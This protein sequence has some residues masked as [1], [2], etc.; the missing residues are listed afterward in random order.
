[1]QLAVGPTA[2]T[3]VGLQWSVNRQLK[4]RLAVGACPTGHVVG[5]RT[6]VGRGGWLALTA[7]A[8]TQPPFDSRLF[9]PILNSAIC[10][11]KIEE[12]FFKKNL[13]LTC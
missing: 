9:L 4:R 12:K 11:R 5:H 8:G 6:A 13:S 10:F 2:A 3:A 1:V 7:V